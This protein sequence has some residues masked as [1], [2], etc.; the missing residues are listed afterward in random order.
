MKREPC[1]KWQGAT[2]IGVLIA[3]DKGLCSR[4]RFKRDKT[5]L[6]ANFQIGGS[7]TR[8]LLYGPVAR[9][10]NGTGLLTTTWESLE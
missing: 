3:K 5:R 4:A 2:F 9:E 8:L 10:I 7:G 1:V 6:E